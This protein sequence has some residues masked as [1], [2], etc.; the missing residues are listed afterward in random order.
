MKIKN[1]YLIIILKSIL[2]N[3]TF[4]SQSTSQAT[5]KNHQ[6]MPMISENELK[7][8]M[9]NAVEEYKRLPEAEKELMSQQIGIKREELDEIMNEA[10][11]FVEEINTKN[12][13][14]STFDQKEENTFNNNSN[15]RLPQAQIKSTSLKNE[16]KEQITI[17]EKAIKTLQTLNLK[18]SDQ[19]IREK[20]ISE[21]DIALSSIEKIV[22]YLLLI[23]QFLINNENQIIIPNADINKLLSIAHKINNLKE[24]IEKLITLNEYETTNNK[25]NLFAKYNIKKPSNTEL[26]IYLENEITLLKKK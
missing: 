19:L 20:I 8:I 17:F 24:S 7:E 11:N 10:S 9:Q 22:Y 21:F 3:T 13:K 15:E 16:T 26:K 5:T 23:K 2:L 6:Q 1:I 25:N 14:K 12:N 4:T 18:A